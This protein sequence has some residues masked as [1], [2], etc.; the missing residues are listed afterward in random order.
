MRIFYKYM[1]KEFFRIFGMFLLAFVLIYLM[2]D[3]FRKLGDFASSESLLFVIMPYFLLKIPLI[4]SQ[5]TPVA[6]LLSVIIF[7]S[8]MLKNY[9]LVALRASGIGLM[10]CSVPIIICG[11]FVVILSFIISELVV[12]ATTSRSNDIWRLHVKKIGPMHSL[13]RNNIWYKNAET[14]SIYWISRFNPEKNEI[15]DAS[16]YFFKKDD[17]SLSRRV[18]IDVAE[19]DGKKWVAKYAD[20]IA[21]KAEGGFSSERIDNFALPIIETPSDFLKIERKPE[22]L[23]YWELK[24]FARRVNAEGY[25]NTRY[26]VESN[27]KLA[28]PF[29]NLILV[30]AGIPIVLG[31]RFGG[32]PMA[33][34]IGVSVCFLYLMTMGIFRSFGIAGVIPPILSAW[35]ANGILFF[36]TLHFFIKM[37]IS[38][39]FVR[40]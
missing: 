2:I 23:N 5:M 13:G 3:F 6:T 17:F 11:C 16:L 12:P 32:T 33:I 27:I 19:W 38:G 26:V 15:R 10:K 7:F 29:V 9:E 24:E 30:I 4:V 36:F 1:L 18:S 35:A 40:R 21:S 28:M 37:D 22:E 8:L 20:I 14:G 34:F 39:I 31:L 25:D